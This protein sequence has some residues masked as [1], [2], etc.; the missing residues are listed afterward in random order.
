[1]KISIFK[2]TVFLWF[3]SMVY[4]GAQK[5]CSKWIDLNWAPFMIPNVEFN[6]ENNQTELN[7]RLIELTGDPEKLIRQHALWTVQ[8]LY[9]YEDI[10]SIPSI[11]KIIYTIQ[12]KDAVVLQPADGGVFRLT[13]DSDLLSQAVTDKDSVLQS[14]RKDLFHDLAFAYMRASQG[15]NNNEYDIIRASLLYAVGIQAELYS[16]EDRAGNGKWQDGGKQTGFFL[17]WLTHKDPKFFKLLNHS[18]AS[19]SEWSFDGVVKQI[20]GPFHGVDGLWKEYLLFLQRSVPDLPERCAR[21]LK[22]RSVVASSQT[23]TQEAIEHVVDGKIE[24]KWCATTASKW[25]EIELEEKSA[26]CQWW[27]LHG[28]MERASWITSDFRL[29]YHDNQKWVD[30]DKVVGN[31]VNITDRVVTPVETSKLRF[32]VSK[33][34]QNG[35]AA[36]RIYEF[37]LYGRPIQTSIRQ[38]KVNNKKN[39]P[40]NIP[41]PVKTST[42]FRI[43]SADFVEKL[44]L[45]VYNMTG[46][47]VDE[48][49][50][51]PNTIGPVQFTWNRKDIPSGA[52][53]YIIT[54]QYR[55]DSSQLSGMMLIQ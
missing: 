12:D 49:N 24:T 30:L 47:L 40:V 14:I 19:L 2:I 50:Y 54:L 7:N 37:K 41:N 16:F 45:E 1:M 28:G 46:G 20:F 11:Q 35:N 27:V 10:A 5:A 8:L 6:N 33:A 3:S 36:A 17:Q 38:P 31:K 13:F 39:Q 22:I 53:L 4:V 18:F 23:N 48:F 43:F 29:Q 34:E 51:K 9:D 52:Y 21:E 25:F 55:N 15:G 42:D 32:I 26:V 44:H